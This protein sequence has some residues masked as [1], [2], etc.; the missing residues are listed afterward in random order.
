MPRTG[1]SL[2]HVG[3]HSPHFYLLAPCQASTMIHRLSLDVSKPS[4]STIALAI[5][6]TYAILT[7]A[8]GQYRR[9][10]PSRSWS[11]LH[12]V[13]SSVYSST[14]N[15]LF[16]SLPK[17]S[18]HPFPRSYHARTGKLFNERMAEHHCA[19]GGWEKEDPNNVKRLANKRIPACR[20]LRRLSSSHM[21]TEP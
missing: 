9:P 16:P 15:L 11:H 14:D 2:P 17:L 5:L 7:T 13:A 20:C 8:L 12:P 6:F 4:S 21:C 19:E 3:P 10:H 18:A 1:S